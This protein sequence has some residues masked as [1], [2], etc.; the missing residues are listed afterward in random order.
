MISCLFTEKE[1][2]KRVSI[3]KALSKVFFEEKPLS[4]REIAKLTGLDEKTFGMG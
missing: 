1:M 3:A 4:A 2:A